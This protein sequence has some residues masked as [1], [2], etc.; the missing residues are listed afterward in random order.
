MQGWFLALSE[1]KASENSMKVVGT[2]LPALTN[3]PRLT[4]RQVTA[5][6]VG[7]LGIWS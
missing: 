7:G 6:V 3:A 4:T 2:A 1:S 5:P